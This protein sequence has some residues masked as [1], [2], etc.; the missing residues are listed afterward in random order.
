VADTG[1]S[2]GAV[3]ELKLHTHSRD[4]M[5]QHEFNVVAFSELVLFIENKPVKQNPR[6]PV[7]NPHYCIL[8]TV[9]QNNLAASGDLTPVNGFD[10]IR[11][12]GQSLGRS[13]TTRNQQSPS[14]TAG[15]YVHN[16]C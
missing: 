15:Q 2:N 8:M 16:I 4:L 6:I 3:S 7:V 13:R 11:Q 14:F 1:N 9:L 5:W 10:A 12:S